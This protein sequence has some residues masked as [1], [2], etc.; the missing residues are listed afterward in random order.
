[1]KPSGAPASS[2]EVLEARIAP[3][4]GAN[5]HLD[6][7]NG[8]NGFRIDSGTA[9]QITGSVSI[10]GDVNGDGLDDFMVATLGEEHRG[11][12]YVIF[13][14]ADGFPATLT[15][16]AL[17]GTDGFRLDG[18]RNDFADR[19]SRAGDVNGDGF[20][21][22]LI[23][24]RGK[25]LPDYSYY[26]GPYHVARPGRCYVVF[27]HASAFAPV[28][29][30]GSL[31]GTDGFRIVDTKFGVLG[32]IVGS[33]GD[34]NGDGFDDITFGNSEYTFVL[35]GKAGGFAASRKASKLTEADGFSIVY[36]HASSATPAG[37]FKAGAS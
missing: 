26:G 27:G 1:M 23:G 28:V 18:A 4:F 13:G 9:G 7:L 30:L 17:D 22:L 6:L 29:N 14:H 10:A 12:T 2:I 35:F 34:I 3:A 25:F 31:N 37:S 5:L 20:D 24:A 21:D 36:P 32:G 11:S 15:L 33:A 19:V 16:S 8:G